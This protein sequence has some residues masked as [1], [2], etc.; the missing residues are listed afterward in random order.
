MWNPFRPRGQGST[1]RDPLDDFWYAAI[2]PAAYGM[3]VDGASALQ[4]TTYFACVK[5]IAETISQLPLQTFSRDRNGDKRLEDQHP[6]YDLLQSSP[7]DEQTAIEW[8]E[9]MAAWCVMRGTAMSEIVPGRRGAVDQLVPLFPDWARVVSAVDNSGR[10][11]YQIE[12]R[13]PG[14]PMRRLLRDEVFILRALM[15]SPECPVLGVD[16]LSASS[17]AIGAALAAQDYA[18][19]FFQNDARPS[20]FIKHPGHFHSEDDRSVFR[21]AWDRAFSGVRRHGT[22]VLEHGMEYQS[23][24]VTPEQAQFLETRKHSDIDIA[25]MMRVPPHK[26]GILDRATFSN[27]EHQALEFVT[28]TIM[29][30]LIR[31]EQAIKKQLIVGRGFFAEHNVDGLLRGDLESRY[32]AYMTGRQGGWLS[33]NEIRRRE[34]LPRIP[35]GGDEY[36]NPLNMEPAGGREGG[37]PPGRTNGAASDHVYDERMGRHIGLILQGTNH[38]T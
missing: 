32:R 6:I 7:N 17:R 23:I 31:W 24:S 34:N 12:Y 36:L 13:E 8:R 27:I 22:A 16:P 15:V 35:S 30:W 28:D 29:P 18:G 19:R 11:Q 38:V 5:V 33:V 1:P 10:S 9:Q 25:R 20:G 37:R 14:A 21:K 2:S 4:L 26:V 3:R